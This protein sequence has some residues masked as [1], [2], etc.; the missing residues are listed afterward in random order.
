MI[1]SLMPANWEYRQL[2]IATV[3]K[4]GLPFLESL[5]EK[6]KTL[7]SSLEG[8][9][10][11]LG[12]F[13]V[14]QCI[15]TDCLRGSAAAG[16]NSHGLSPSDGSLIMALLCP[17]WDSPSDDSRVMEACNDWIREV[18]EDAKEKGLGHRY[19][20]PNYGWLGQAVLEG[21][22]DSSLKKLKKTAEKWD[23]DG[24]F[25]KAVPGGYK[26]SNCGK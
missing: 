20:F 18:E 17:V 2:Y 23:R 9:V 21:Y 16:G 22:G 15:T 4:P 12:F 11:G 1:T 19:I 24:F 7:V 10:S 26:L 8:P 3:F 13:L 14:L 5:Y 6:F 25:Q